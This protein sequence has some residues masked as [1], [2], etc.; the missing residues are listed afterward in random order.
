MTSS[1]QLLCRQEW[2]PVP[3]GG[4]SLSAARS[5]RDTN[6]D[7]RGGSNRTPPLQSR[8]PGG[9]RCA[10]D[11]GR[12][13]RSISRRAH[14]GRSS[15]CFSLAS[16]ASGDQDADSWMETIRFFLFMGGGVGLISAGLPLLVLASGR[17][18][19]GGDLYEEGA[20]R[21]R[22]LLSVQIASAPCC[23]AVSCCP[24]SETAPR[25]PRVGFDDGLDRGHRRRRTRQPRP[26]RPAT[27]AYELHSQLGTSNGRLGLRIQRD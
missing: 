5:C 16:D 17:T 6:R 15:N 2:C 23:P 8:R 7:Q 26:A 19:F 14:R 1:G 27:L 4:D 25:V 24:S 9:D 11:L 22:W 21:D 12:V 13:W 10:D 3:E 18:R 20:S